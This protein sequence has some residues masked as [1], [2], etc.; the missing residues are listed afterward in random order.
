MWKL[1]IKLWAVWRFT[2][3]LALAG[4]VLWVIYQFDGPGKVFGWALVVSVLGAAAVYFML[5]DFVRREINHRV[6]GR[7]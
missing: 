2:L 1:G 5:R 4:G 7:L 3:Y 6:A